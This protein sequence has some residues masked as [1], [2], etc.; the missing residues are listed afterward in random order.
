MVNIKFVPKTSPH[1]E[2]AGNIIYRKNTNF[3]H[4]D[5]HDQSVKINVTKIS[6]KLATACYTKGI[7]YTNV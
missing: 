4:L 1:I 7:N 2:H 6:Y 5:L 3:Q